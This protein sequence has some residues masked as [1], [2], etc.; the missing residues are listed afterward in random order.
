MGIVA[1]KD[2][3]KPNANKAQKSNKT[4]TPTLEDVISPKEKR[5]QS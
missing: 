5:Q 1:M 4:K 2:Q 3:I